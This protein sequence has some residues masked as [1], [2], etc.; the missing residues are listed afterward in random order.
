[1]YIYIYI[2]NYPNIE[3]ENCNG[4]KIKQIIY[5]VNT[6]ILYIESNI[7]YFFNFNIFFI[8]KSNFLVIVFIAI[9]IMIK[10]LLIF[11]SMIIHSVIIRF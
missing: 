3:S 6:N 4:T 8:S 1:M 10:I 5:H 2:A 11:D 9:S 7:L